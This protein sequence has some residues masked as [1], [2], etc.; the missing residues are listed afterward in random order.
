MVTMGREAPRVFCKT[1]ATGVVSAMN[2]QDVDCENSRSGN[3]E[4]LVPNETELAARC[5]EDL[6]AGGVLLTDIM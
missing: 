2:W 1:G 6:I 3:G 5:I 4:Q